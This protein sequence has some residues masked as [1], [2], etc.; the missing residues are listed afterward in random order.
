M[1]P[2]GRGDTLGVYRERELRRKFTHA[3]G[4][5]GLAGAAPAK[6]LTHSVHRVL[7]FF[8]FA[9][10]IHIFELMAIHMSFK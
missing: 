1:S 3:L 8:Q 6:L 9:F 10:Q 5:N 7:Q 4:N 2:W